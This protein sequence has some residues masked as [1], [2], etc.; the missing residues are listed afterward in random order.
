MRSQRLPQIVL[1]W[2]AAVWAAAGVMPAD[3]SPIHCRLALPAQA[4]WT[5]PLPLQMTLHNPG[6]QTLNVLNWHTPFE[7]FFSRYLK[8]T[9]PQGELAYG[10]ALA[11][12]GSPQR[13][14]YLSI[15]SG[16]SVTTSVDLRD[17]YKFDVAGIYRVEYIGQLADVSTDAKRR[18]LEQL[19]ATELQCAAV[20]VH[21][22][23]PK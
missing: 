7:G 23:A 20:T 21:L 18:K 22:L 4:A 19:V 6:K 17:V 1:V 15:A 9:G 3:A 13:D 10:G 14:E 2:A 12:R 16:K 5:A 8:V 11:K